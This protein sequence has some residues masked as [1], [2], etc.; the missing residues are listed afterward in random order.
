[1]PDE[2][3][4]VDKTRDLVEL[5]VYKEVYLN[6]CKFWSRLLIYNYHMSTKSLEEQVKSIKS[7]VLYETK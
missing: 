4:Y 1:M 7:K 5:W 6:K 2:N 3:G